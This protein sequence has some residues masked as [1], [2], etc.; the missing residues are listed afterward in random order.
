MEKGVV[1]SRITTLKNSLFS[2]FLESN[3]ISLSSF[4]V[5]LLQGE[6]KGSDPERQRR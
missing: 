1:M 3:L 4:L 6:V 5:P 2:L